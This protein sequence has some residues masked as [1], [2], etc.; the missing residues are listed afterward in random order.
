[1]LMMKLSEIREAYEELSGKLSE[2]NR[3]LCFAGFAI[4]WI[5][6]KSMGDF[7]VPQELYLP[8]FFLCASLFSDLLQYIVSS[9]SWYIYY[10]R[11]RSNNNEDEDIQ[12]DEPEKLN[13]APWILFFLKIILLVTGYVFIGIFLFLKL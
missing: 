9:I 2:I 1:M 10:L 12:V 13:I 11:K 6:N 4:I 5:F 8:A 7:S 3:Q